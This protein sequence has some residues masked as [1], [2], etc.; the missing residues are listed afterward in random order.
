MTWHRSGILITAA[1]VVLAACGGPFRKP[2]QAPHEI[3]LTEKEWA[4]E[5]KN[6]RVAAGMVTITVINQGTVEHNFV[7]E[8]VVTIERIQPRES[9]A[10]Q[11]NLSPGTY[12]LLC[13]LPGHREA[14]MTA[15]L[16][17]E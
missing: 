5:P 17:V 13:T 16:R 7:I 14:G 10:V 8:R 11:V 6:A 4:I 1:A 2:A 3:R 15:I 9:K 12:Q